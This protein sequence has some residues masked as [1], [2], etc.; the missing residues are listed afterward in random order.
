MLLGHK[1]SDFLALFS[2]FPCMNRNQE[3]RNLSSQ[4][5]VQGCSV[6]KMFLKMLENS[7]ESTGCR[8]SFL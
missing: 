6:E 7:Q 5:V 1:L 2:L 4:V 3:I 8:V